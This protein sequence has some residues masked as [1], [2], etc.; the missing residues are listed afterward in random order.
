[1]AVSILN[2]NGRGHLE[3]C[4]ES[5]DS[6][7]D[8]G[9]EWEVLIL[10]NAST[11]DSWAWLEENWP[12][13]RRIGGAGRPAP[14]RRFRAE[15]NLGFCD[16][17]NWLA[18][19][20]DADALALLNNDTR[21][22]HDWL[23]ALVASLS[24]AAPDVAAVSGL[25]LDWEGLKLDFAEGAMTF[26]GHAFQLG[27]HRSLD[28]AVLPKPG[29]ELLFACGGNM[30][31]RRRSFVQAGGFDSAFFAYLEDVDLGWRLWSGGERIVAAPEA[32][33]H[34][35]SMA[36]SDLLGRFNRGF[37]FERNAFL[38]AYK[39]YD[40]PLWPQMMPA[41]LLTFLSRTQTLLVENNPHGDSFTL[42]PYDPHLR[43]LLDGRQP[44]REG[45]RKR[46]QRYG[47]TGMMRRAIHKARRE[48]ARRIEPE[49]LDSGVPRIEDPRTLAQLRAVTYMLSNLD[50]AAKSRECIQKRRKRADCELFER[51][52]LLVVPTY[53]GD[54][55][56]FGSPAFAAWLPKS[57]SFERRSLGEIMELSG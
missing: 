55:H 24:S 32:V 15:R 11:D 20:T 50:P 26:D 4:L 33:V 5:I 12:E 56:L 18:E 25:I 44:P 1:M 36:T 48:L 23:R 42:D 49:P 2:W 53:P 10:D 39:N 51:F 40:Q 21:V 28:T 37:L 45:L 31:V 6:Q 16:G 27:Y 9:V 46:W 14:V 8:P 57:L 41:V 34:H 47:S 35:R 13:K 54:E 52:P 43:G 19:Q 30:L 22:R 29:D 3:R 7:V 38:T 17:N